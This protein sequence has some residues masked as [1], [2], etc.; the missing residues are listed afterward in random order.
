MILEGGKRVCDPDDEFHGKYET[1][2]LSS[3][4]FTS[5]NHRITVFGKQK[6]YILAS[7]TAHVYLKDHVS[8]G[9]ELS[10][11]IWIVEHF[12]Y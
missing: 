7:R 1:A 11:A 9:K 6:N 12:L 5:S 10:I 4:S 8:R 3:W 2:N